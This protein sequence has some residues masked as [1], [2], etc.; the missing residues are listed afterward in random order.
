MTRYGNDILIPACTDPQDSLSWRQVQ[1][2]CLVTK[3]LCIQ[4]YSFT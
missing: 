1:N 4:K 2:M 3:P